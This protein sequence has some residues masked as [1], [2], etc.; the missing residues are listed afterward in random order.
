MMG[1]KVEV[2]VVGRVEWRGGDGRERV[3]KWK[4]VEGLEKEG[5]VFWVGL[6]GGVFVVGVEKVVEEVCVGLRE[7]GG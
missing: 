2:E 7:V 1:G 6:L 3:K 5:M 4:F